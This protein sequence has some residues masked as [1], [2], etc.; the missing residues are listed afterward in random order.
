MRIQSFTRHKVV[1]FWWAAVFIFIV[2]I[3][4][5]YPV[6]QKLSLAAAPIV[7]AVQEPF[8]WA[9]KLSLWFAD[10]SKLQHKLL[11]LQDKV[12]QQ[13]FLLQQIAVVKE[14]NSQLKRLL[15]V[16]N[17]DGYVWQVARVLSRSL[18]EK[19][20]R[21][22]IQTLRV[23]RDDIVISHEGLVGLVDE[24]LSNY[25]VVRTILDASI[26]VPVTKKGSQ[27]AALVRGDGEHL[28]VDFIPRDKAPEVGDI[29][30][31]S[32]AGGVFP[33]GLPVATVEKVKAV[34]GGVFVKVIATPVAYWQRDMWLAVVS[35]EHAH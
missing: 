35:K 16:V 32:G 1:Y 19:S 14:E 27:L 13:R 21:L 34:P 33:A 25:A 17:I 7:R 9:E 31:S 30:V 8:F 2:L 26:A 5:K 29:L 3:T 23:D 4:F 15:H 20:R 28:Q 22:M 24:S 18:E 6:G 10:R 11:N 12:L